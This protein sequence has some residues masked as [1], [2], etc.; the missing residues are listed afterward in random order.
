MLSVE[1]EVADE[2]GKR[3]GRERVG[4]RKRW[5]QL[6]EAQVMVSRRIH[7]IHRDFRL[8]VGDFEA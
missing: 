8:T 4:E 2:G 7:R 5:K 6:S 3:S 1:G